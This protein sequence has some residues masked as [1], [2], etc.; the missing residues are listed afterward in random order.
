MQGLRLSDGITDIA[1]SV[2]PMTISRAYSTARQY[3]VAKALSEDGGE[4]LLRKALQELSVAEGWEVWGA[5][6]GMQHGA[7]TSHI[8]LALA[9]LTTADT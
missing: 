5:L 3:L 7:V 1:Q 9:S 8:S 6:H 4:G 2:D